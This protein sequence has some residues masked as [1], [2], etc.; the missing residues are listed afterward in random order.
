MVL[1]VGFDS[2][3]TYQN[4]IVDGVPTDEP[5]A[6]TSPAWTPGISERAELSTSSTLHP[7]MTV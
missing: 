1:A 5:G 7:R 6:E 4:D 2:E 3:H